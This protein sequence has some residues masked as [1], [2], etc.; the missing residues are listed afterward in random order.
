MHKRA[1]W[2]F[3]IK[4][5]LQNNKSVIEERT[6]F[7]TATYTKTITASGTS[8]LKISISWTDP[9]APNK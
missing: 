1:Q 2:Q 4:I 5:L 3:V 7:N 9:Q 6:L 8:P